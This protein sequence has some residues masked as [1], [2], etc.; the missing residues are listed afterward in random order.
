MKIVSCTMLVLALLAAAAWALAAFTT[1]PAAPLAVHRWLPLPIACVD[2]RCVTYIRFAGIVRSQAGGQDAA[3][4]LTELLTSKA[5]SLVA[6]RS[7]LQV[8]ERDVDAALRTLDELVAGQPELQ[9]FL[10]AQYGTVRDERFRDG[11][12]DLLLQRKLSAAGIA[13]PWEHPAAPAVTILS[14]RYR[15][16]NAAHKVVSR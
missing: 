11:I 4:I 2:A 9:E 7:G 8:S 12:R 6:R 10:A 14:A 1:V 3:R 16:D 13:S 15:W 5:S